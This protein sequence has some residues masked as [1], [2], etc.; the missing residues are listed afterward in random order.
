MATIE[1]VARAVGVSASTVSRA[2]TRPEMV[3]KATRDRVVDAAQQLG[4]LEIARDRSAKNQVGSQIAFLVT[5]L[6]NP[7]YATLIKGVQ[8][9]AEQYDYNILLYNTEDQPDKEARYLTLA[10]QYRVQGL[11]LIPTQNSEERLEDFKD[12]PVIEVDRYS[13]LPNVHSVMAENVRGAL[14]GVDHLIGLGHKRIA[15]VC[16]TPEVSTTS[17]RLEGYR[18]AM[19]RAKLT[20]DP[21]WITYGNNVEAGGNE[22]T[23][24]LM[25]LPP[26]SRPTALFVTNSEM[27][28]GT[29]LALRELGLKVPRD[30]SLVG[31]DDP[32]WAQ[33]MDPPLTVVA[34]PTF[35][36]GRVAC[37]I[38]IQEIQRDLQLPAL[39]IRLATQL[40][41]RQS[42]RAI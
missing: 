41:V 29:V 24:A 2:I 19:T 25:S 40:V 34:Q 37:E 39:Q 27:A 10:R 5:D 3:S 30:V 1:D 21:A 20:V 42:T 13:G 35:E 22:A 17:E 15:I 7:T 4:Y 31:F 38:L 36:M 9:V 28:A 33:L 12:I 23:R 18:Q 16:G 14:S 8:E 6:L 11:L 26:S 32:R